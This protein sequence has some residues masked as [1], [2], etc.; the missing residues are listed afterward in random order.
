MSENV[1]KT[2][3][4]YIG[5]GI[6]AKDIVAN[7]QVI[8]VMPFER[9]PFVEG[10]ISNALIPAEK[11]GVDADGQHYLVKLDF[12][13]CVIATWLKEANIWTAPN[14]VAGE[15]VDLYTVGDTEMYY[16]KEKG[17]KTNLRRTEKLVM[18]WAASGASK[19]GPIRQSADN[20]YCLYVDTDTGHLTLRTSKDRGE[21]R[22]ITLQVNTKAGAVLVSDNDGSGLD[23]DFVN[24][25]LKLYTKSGALVEL[26]KSTVRAK[27]TQL[28]CTFDSALLDIDEVTLNGKIL[29]TNVPIMNY[30]GVS[31]FNGNVGVNGTFSMTG[32][33][34]TATFGGSVTFD[35][36]VTFKKKVT[37]P[38][39]YFKKL[40]C[41]TLAGR[42]VDQAFIDT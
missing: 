14:V 40:D 18:A 25:V 37:G 20:H 19:G 30:T 38:E 27:G 7:S 36:D 22:R 35:A 23:L 17:D 42:P 10:G 3:M 9:L 21:P 12:S 15:T 29:T 34:S 8:E 31:Q 41:E 4:R 11:A 13:Q 33:G 16:W 24:E 32:D 1:E 39:A 2:A 6:V 26:D 28:N 5:L